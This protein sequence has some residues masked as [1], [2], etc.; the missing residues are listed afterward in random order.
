MHLNKILQLIAIVIVA[1]VAFSFLGVL[2]KIGTVL[3]GIALRVLILLL[4]AVIILRL[5]ALLIS[6]RS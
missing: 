4:V 6:R 3:L 5:L 1:L 2:L